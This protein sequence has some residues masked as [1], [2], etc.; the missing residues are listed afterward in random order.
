M[1]RRDMLMLDVVLL[2]SVLD[3]HLVME[4]GVMIL[5]LWIVVV[6]VE[7]K[8]AEAAERMLSDIVIVKKVQVSRIVCCCLDW[9]NV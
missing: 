4:D 9:E 6:L 3:M 1:V 5:L 2:L 8:N 7:C